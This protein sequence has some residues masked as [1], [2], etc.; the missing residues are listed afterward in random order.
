VRLYKA[1]VSRR[2]NELRNAPNVP[3]W[4]RNYYEHIIRNQASLDRI[5]AYI[6]NNPSR[7]E[8]DQLHPDNPSRW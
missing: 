2:I 7:W 5:R 1:A 8:P 6:A 4:Q 3:V